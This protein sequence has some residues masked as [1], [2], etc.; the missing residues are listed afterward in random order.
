MVYSVNVP[1][2]LFYETAI[3]QVQHRFDFILL[4][5]L[6]RGKCGHAAKIGVDLEFLCIDKKHCK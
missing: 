6:L 5:S 1:I 3:L 2:F 4:S